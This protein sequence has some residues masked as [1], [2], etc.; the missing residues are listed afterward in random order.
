[1]EDRLQ[2]CAR[3]IGDVGILP[4]ERNGIS[5]EVP[6]PEVQC[7]GTSWHGELLIERTVA[8]RLYTGDVASQRREGP[9][10]HLACADDRIVVMTVDYPWR[11]AAGLE[12]F[13]LNDPAVTRSWR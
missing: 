4:I 11:K 10:M 13:V 3:G 9:A 8:S 6:V 5:S 12:S 2:D 7:A 1:M